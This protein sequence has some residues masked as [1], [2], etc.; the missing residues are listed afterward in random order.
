VLAALDHLTSI[1]DTY[2]ERAA[3]EAL[4]HVTHMIGACVRPDD[5][6]GRY[7]GQELLIVL[8][9]CDGTMAGAFAERIRGWITAVPLGVGG[10][11]VSL[12]VSLGVA[13][14]PGGRPGS[15]MALLAAADAALYRA[16][17]EGGNRAA[18]AG[19]RELSAGRSCS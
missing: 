10:S 14:Q 16:K 5:A 4:R 12:S 19:E 1:A 17:A 9:R 8:R 3:D 7:G 13:A 18:V 2:G 11:H 15:P 6:L